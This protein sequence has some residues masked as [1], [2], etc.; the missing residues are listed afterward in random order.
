MNFAELMNTPRPFTALAEWCACM[1]YILMLPKKLKG[2]KLAASLAGMFVL[3]FS[4]HQLSGT[5]P[6]YL[7]F[8]GMIAAILLMY[9]C[10]YASCQVSPYDAGFLCVRAFVLAEFAAS[11]QWQLYVWWALSYQ[12]ENRV[13][14]VIIM[15][16]SYLCLYT[17]YYFLEKEHIPDDEGM[18]VERKELLGAA[19]IALGAF[20]MSNISFVMPNT[21]FSSATSSLLYVRTLVDFGGLIMLYAQQNR[22]KE[23]RVRSENHAMNVV[24]QRQYDQYR[25]A[26]D[27]T[28]LLRREFHDLKHYMIA[29]RAEQ[30]PEKKEQYL[31]EMEKAILTQE[32][33]ANTGNQVLDVV[34]TTKS[35]Y[36]TQNKI[37]FTCMAD[38]KLISFLHVKDICSIFGNALDNAIE[39][40]S[41]FDDPEKRLISLSIYKKNGFLMICCENYSENPLVMAGS[42]L[43]T[44]TKSNKQ[45]HGY[46]LKSIQA[47]AQKY[48]GTMTISSK[49]NWFIL[50]VLIPVGENTL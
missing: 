12:R 19:S 2:F 9:F 43:P 50:Q 18:R 16:V 46:G 10:L 30:D 8:P 21:P 47:A 4:L 39:C 22:R 37:S 31:L 44:T 29:I 5:F 42:N 34:I 11:F 40:V 15:L 1:I 14:S 49:D 3:F 6:L 33:L 26:I 41:Q 7:W 13:L 27:S 32:A 23:L 28:E 38:G 35:T 36:C 17:G 45:Y 25:M 48:G 24:L 20:L